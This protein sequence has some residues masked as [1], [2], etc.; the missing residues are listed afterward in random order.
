LNKL[1]NAALAALALSIS[2]LLPDVSPRNLGFSVNQSQKF[3]RSFSETG[4]ALV[5]EQPLPAPA[6]QNRQFRQERRSLPQEQ[7]AVRPIGS[8]SVTG[9]PQYQHII[10]NTNDRT[11]LQGIKMLP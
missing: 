3:A 1:S 9:E 4:S 8:G 5:S 11:G 6:R 10:Y 2:F 7:T